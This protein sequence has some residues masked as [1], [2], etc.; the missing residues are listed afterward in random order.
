M[1]PKAESN[2]SAF[3]ILPAS[4]NV[5]CAALLVFGV[6]QCFVGNRDQFFSSHVRFEPQAVLNAD[7]HRQHVTDS[8]GVVGNMQG[9]NVLQ[10]LTCFVFALFDADVRN[11]QQKFVPP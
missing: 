2:G 8:R 3:L 1:N 11:K 7:G 6:K 4:V 5:Q 9:L 10:Q